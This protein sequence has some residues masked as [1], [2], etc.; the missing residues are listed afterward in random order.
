M[1][2]GNAQKY[3]ILFQT[4][5]IKMNYALDLGSIVFKAQLKR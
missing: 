3:F 2:P 5:L 4:W 1:K